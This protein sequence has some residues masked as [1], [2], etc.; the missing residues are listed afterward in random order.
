MKT[1]YVL[2]ISLLGYLMPAHACNPYCEVKA[3]NGTGWAL[4][5]GIEKITTCTLFGVTHCCC[6]PFGHDISLDG[7]GSHVTVPN[8]TLFRGETILFWPQYDHVSENVVMKYSENRYQ[9]DF[10]CSER[11]PGH[12]VALFNILQEPVDIA[13]VDHMGND[14][15]QTISPGGQG[16][17]AQNENI[18]VKLSSTGQGYDLG[19]PSPRAPIGCYKTCPAGTSPTPSKTCPEKST[20]RCRVSKPNWFCYLLPTE[21]DACAKKS[22]KAF[23]SEFINL[24]PVD[25]N[26]SVDQDD[27]QT[28]TL[29]SAQKPIKVECRA[30]TGI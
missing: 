22:N 10:V 12:R 21:G 20:T 24:E 9:P 11:Y 29:N 28:G 13:Y 1:N 23:L 8:G 15:V 6:L 27:S 19:L 16:C 2:I 4:Y 25:M 26:L 30:D 18:V 5:A 14:Q 3:C 7:L 17:V